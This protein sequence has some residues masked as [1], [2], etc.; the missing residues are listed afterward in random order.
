ME[1]NFL[2]VILGGTTGA[3]AG[4]FAGFICSLL[5]WGLMTGLSF[6]LHLNFRGEEMFPV[7]FLS[8]GAG[9]FLGGIFGGVFA[10][11]KLK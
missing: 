10:L 2:T 3:I 9:A 7:F 1:K 4:I 11:K 6:G 5:I 8:L